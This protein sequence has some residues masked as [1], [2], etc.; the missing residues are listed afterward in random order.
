MNSLPN[1]QISI[2]T[3]GA[4]VIVR[5]AE[6]IVRRVDHA[7]GGYQIV[8]DGVSELVR[9][10]E[11]VFLTALEPTI[12]VLDPAET[13]LVPDDSAQFTDSILY[14][15]SQLRQAVPNDTE[16]HV[17]H[18]AAMDR[19]DYQLDP[20]RLALARPRQRI[21]IADAVG[22][23]K[24]LEAGVLVSELIARGRGR[25]ILVLAVKSMLTQFQKEFW[26]RF[27]IPLT[28]LDSIGIQRVRSRIPANHNP[29]YYYDKAIISIDTLKQDAEYRTYL[30]QASWD[31]IVI[32]EAHNVADRGTASQ[33]NRLARLL[34]R[35]SDTL[36][37]LSATPHDGKARS[38]ASL[39]NML[40]ATAITNPDDYTK[41]D[42]RPGLVIRR[43]KKDVQEQVRDAFR[44]RQVF[45]QRFSASAAE[46][47]AYDA[48][49]AV[50]VAG[51]RP[52]TAMRDLFAVTLEKAL[53]SSPAACIETVDERI[54]RRER[55]ISNGE[56]ASSMRSE[57]ASLTALRDALVR[58]EPSHY[59]K[60]QAL[61]DGIQGGG[62]FDW[63]P[64]E[65]TDRLV[66][67]TERIATLNWLSARLATDLMLKPGQVET[68]HGGMSDVEQQR[69]VEDFGNTQRPVR[70]LLCSDVASEGIN[71]HYQCHRLIHFDMPWSLMV[72]QQRNGRVDRYGQTA[73][74]QIVYLVTES[75]NPT[76]RGDTRILEVLMAKDEQAYRNIGDPSVFM[77]VHD[78]DEEEEITRKA[79]A[80][81]ESDTDFDHRW[82]PK[83]NKGESLL[84]MF[85]QPEGDEGEEP[86]AA[87]PPPPLSL[88]Q[89]ELDYCAAALHRLQAT[90]A[91]NG[92]AGGPSVGA[93]RLRF[94]VD[95]ES[96]TLTLDAPADLV[97]RYSYLPPEVLPDSRRFVLTTS[98]NRMSEA[99]AESRRAESAWP[100]VHYLWRL[101]PVVGWLNDRVLAAF[102]R[103][104]APTLSGVP[105]LGPDQAIFVFS[106]LVPN[107]KSHPLVYEWIAVSFRGAVFSELIPFK[108][109]LQRTGLGRRAVPNLQRPADLA[110]LSRLL[111]E[112][113][114]RARTHFVE[115]RNA[116]EAIVNAKLDEE[117]RALDEFMA[118]HRRQSELDFAQSRQAEQFRRRRHEQASNE[119]DA[120]YDEYWSWMSETM[121]T[122]PHPWIK[123]ICATT[124]LAQ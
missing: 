82:T 98:R 49:L 70:L 64:T 88:F 11:A 20:A 80:R 116:F 17:G 53:F 56:D 4:R 46:E 73:T 91:E 19:V 84:A 3:P 112:A 44:D 16:I 23:G 9:G 106:G 123:V 29:F 21:L 99:I 25:R 42:F 61:L 117:V 22:L 92:S 34:A 40:D 76:I 114:S 63:R 81:G 124:G 57:I 5:D 119:L 26:N 115:R 109:L 97:A 74:P 32:D 39:V 121:T 31:I 85:L 15:E 35:R 118:R 78:I 107:Q 104:E 77:D 12:E 59:S 33:R 90:R 47:A 72:F 38:F 62:P 96:E 30:E 71:L 103:S 48:L 95:P 111:P 94:A 122:E 14:M 28:R 45:P 58:I 120:I 1:R 75:V 27:T 83:T 69:V 37:M 13:R 52:E 87:T 18:T 110:A 67:F 105:G 79:V 66:I 65:T 93:T 55:E 41:E 68:L 108:A 101:S 6:W 24:T 7:P 51:R 43:F 8:C 113:V 89:S 10:R 86:P 60:Y 100:S 54:K 102:G 36:I 2:P 50:R